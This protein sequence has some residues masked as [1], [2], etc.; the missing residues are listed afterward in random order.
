M[1][2]PEE[3]EKALQRLMPPA[4]S[5]QGHAAV[6]NA[7]ECLAGSNQFAVEVRPAHGQLP[8]SKNTNWI[9]G[10]AAAV[11]LIAGLSFF[12]LATPL[13]TP[14]ATAPIPTPAAA[15]VNLPIFIDRMLLT[16]AVSIEDTVAAADGSMMNQ[17]V[18][19]IHT[20]ERYRDAQH[21]YLITVSESRDENVLIPKTSF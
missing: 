3:I 6:I 7:I 11:A 15:A 19:R 10:A 16:D 1:K 2:S 8:S 12:R 5:D 14:L 17:V 18:R 9:W 20:R 21:G 4:M 13:A